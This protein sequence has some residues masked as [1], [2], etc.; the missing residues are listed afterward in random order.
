MF[1]RG[2][3]NELF[4]AAIFPQDPEIVIP[5]ISAEN[6]WRLLR[7][8]VDTYWIEH[9]RNIVQW[10]LAA[11][12]KPFSELRL[13]EK[14]LARL[15]KEDTK[16][17]YS[18]ISPRDLID[19]IRTFVRKDNLKSKQDDSSRLTNFEIIELEKLYEFMKTE[20]G[21]KNLHDGIT[22]LVDK[23][24]RELLLRE[25]EKYNKL[26]P[27]ENDESWELRGF[28]ALQE[29]IKILDNIIL[30]LSSKKD[31]WEL[32]DWY[33][34]YVRNML[35]RY[36]KKEAEFASK[37]IDNVRALMKRGGYGLLYKAGE[38]LVSY[39]G[40]FILWAHK[41]YTR[42]HELKREASADA[43]NKN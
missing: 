3:L 39:E 38:D 33:I 40:E 16:H 26:V 15:N 7:K 23:W 30:L 10:N 22:E 19:L 14:H 1:K 31:L 20:D 9:V 36:Y 29:A 37:N 24:L 32:V 4:E 43:L 18:S 27:E 25:Q 13:C 2:T 8:G 6:T 12:L 11:L 35:I 34:S 42:L 21:R 41:Y 5:D 28:A 17:E